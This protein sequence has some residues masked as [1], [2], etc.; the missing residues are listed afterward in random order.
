MQVDVGVDDT[1][2]RT[3]DHDGPKLPRRATNVQVLERLAPVQSARLLHLHDTEG[4]FGGWTNAPL[5]ASLFGTMMQYYLL[6]GA[7]CC[8][9]QGSGNQDD[10]RVYLKDPPPLRIS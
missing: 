3:D 4:I 9:S 5:E 8:T 10:G 2:V 6:R 1:G 7:W